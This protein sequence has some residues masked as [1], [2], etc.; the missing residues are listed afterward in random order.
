MTNHMVI[1]YQLHLQGAH[2]LIKY[3]MIRVTTSLNGQETNTLLRLIRKLKCE[4]YFDK[5]ALSHC[6]F[7][8][9]R[10][11][12]QD[13]S[14]GRSESHTSS[15]KKYALAARQSR[16]IAEI[17]KTASEEINGLEILGRL[18]SKL[19]DETFNAMENCVM[20]YWSQDRWEEAE[21]LL[22]EL[23]E[24]LRRVNTADNDK[25]RKII[26]TMGNLSSTY[27]HLHRLAD[28]ERLG[29]ETVKACK[30]IFGTEHHLT[31][32]SMGNL[33]SVY[34]DLHRLDLAEKVQIEVLELSKKVLGENSPQILP[35]MNNLASTYYYQRRFEEADALLSNALKMKN[36]ILGPGHPSTILTIDN[37]A[38][39]YE[40]Q[41]RLDDTVDLLISALNGWKLVPEQ[42]A[43][44]VV[45]HLASIYRKQGRTEEAEAVLHGVY[46]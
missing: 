23:L 38:D 21:K 16:H 29:E 30:E 26:S 37:L 15:D 11:N 4:P 42:D 33:A 24:T 9:Q 22:V 3:N 36:E 32:D 27:R 19:G 17:D 18:L 6:L 43:F 13:H 34:G 45:E 8:L 25:D 39:I 7:Y 35:A 40:S 41:N 2:N 31:L 14:G 28:A 46:P 12:Y 44:F 20:S 5:I 1:P 10:F